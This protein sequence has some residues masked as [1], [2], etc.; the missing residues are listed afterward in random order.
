MRTLLL[1]PWFLTIGSCSSPP[2]PP[3]VDEST[4]RPVNSVL[5]VELQTCKSDLQNTRITAAESVRVA[6]SAAVTVAMLQ[7]RQQSLAAA[8]ASEARDAAAFNEVFTVHFAFSR[9]DLVVPAEMEAG[10]L[11][12][13]RSAPLVLLRGRTD[14]TSESLAEGRIARQRVEVVR[15][16]LLAAGVDPARVRAAH[17][18]IGDHAADNTTQAG[19]G[20]NRRV[21][22]EVYRSLPVAFNARSAADRQQ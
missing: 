10:L 2:N 5:A 9:T 22:I 3:T 13:A 19:R 18:A 15:D 6:Q 17:Q 21:E 11:F 1:L 14:G 16:Y 4:R 12:A 8:A 20:L 7:E